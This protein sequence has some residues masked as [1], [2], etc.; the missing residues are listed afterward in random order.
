MERDG[1]LRLQGQKTVE[2]SIETQKVSMPI[3]FKIKEDGRF[4]IGGIQKES[5]RGMIVSGNII[6]DMAVINHIFIDDELRGGTGKLLLQKLEEQF[7]K[8]EIT[9]VFAIFEKTATIQFFLKN[10]YEIISPESIVEEYNLGVDI[11]AIDDRVHNQKDFEQVS[12]GRD[13]LKKVVLRKE[14]GNK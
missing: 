13:R 6:G 12:E 4:D 11:D 7:E 8:E 9:A 14:I 10:G 3:S 5:N 1:R 2:V